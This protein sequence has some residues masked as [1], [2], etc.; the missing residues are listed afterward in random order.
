LVPSLGFF[1]CLF[2]F[3]IRLSGC[4]ALGSAFGVVFSVMLFCTAARGVVVIGA[5][6]VEL[7]EDAGWSLFEIAAEDFI[8]RYLGCVSYSVFCYGGL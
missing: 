1:S 8:A 3:D 2:G 6:E 4:G 7:A 5:F